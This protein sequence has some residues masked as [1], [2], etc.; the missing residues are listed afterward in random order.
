MAQHDRE[1][2]ERRSALLIALEDE[3]CAQSALDNDHFVRR[4]LE[5]D[6]YWVLSAALAQHVDQLTGALDAFPLP[7]DRVSELLDSGAVQQTWEEASVSQRRE[8]LRLA[9][10]VVRVAP[11][12][13]GHRFD[14]RSRLSFEW[15]ISSAPTARPAP[16]V[17]PAG[18]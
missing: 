4:T 15:A 1:S 17:R 9:L 3:R 12:V 8:L 6:S 10:V 7:K 11:G 2:F 13:R 16:P 14:A 18:A 5:R